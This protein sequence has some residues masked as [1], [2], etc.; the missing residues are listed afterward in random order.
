MGCSNSSTSIN[1]Q[2][3]QHI[4]SQ[5]EEAEVQLLDLQD[6]QLPL[7]GVDL[8]KESG[9]PKNAHR[10]NQFIEANDAIVL[11]LAE[12]NGMPSAAFKNLWDWTSRIDKKFWG[13]KPIF[14]ASTSPGGRGGAN[15]LKIVKGVVPF[16][17]GKVLEEFS[18]PRFYQNFKDGKIIEESF[19]QSLREKIDSFQAK[20][21]A[22]V[23][24]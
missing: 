2:F 8:E 1:R 15:A 14:L 9:I 17:G 11:S 16:F 3:S 23:T 12:H 21:N 20:L 4:A 18:L 7:Y 6:L 10:F 13:E 22:S 5:I 24:T 19:R